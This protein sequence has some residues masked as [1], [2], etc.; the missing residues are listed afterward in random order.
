MADR[1]VAVRLLAKVD[2]YQ[3]GLAKASASTRSFTKEASTGFGSV[4]KSTAS[5]GR[6]AQ[7]AAGVAIAATTAFA[8]QSV[9][10]YAQVQDAQSALEATYGSS[11]AV[12]E[13][14]A[15]TQAAGYHLSQREAL[16][17][18]QTF[19]NFAKAAGLSGTELENF[20]VTL[21]ARAADMASYYGGTVQDAIAAVSSGLMGEQE[22]LRRYGVLL[23]DQTM[24]VKAL[25]MGLISSVKQGL[26]PQ[27]KV[28]TV[29]A[30]LLEK[31]S[32]AAGDAARTNGSLANNLKDLSAGWDDLQ[33]SMGQALAG[34]VTPLLTGANSLLKIVVGLPDPLKMAGAAATIAAAGFVL[35][36]PRIVDSVTAMKELAVTSPK[37]VAGLKGFVGI[38]GAVGVL[39]LAA[40]ALSVAVQKVNDATG[41]GARSSDTW[42][43]KLTDGAT[44]AELGD[45]A[46]KIALATDKG[47]QFSEF[48]RSGI[49]AKSTIDQAKT[50]VSNLDA[51]LSRMVS[52]G[53]AQLA[54]NI[55]QSL[56]MDAGGAAETLPAYTAA[57]AAA[58]TA[59]EGAVPPLK[60]LTNGFQSATTAAMTFDT[61]W[62]RMTGNLSNA[63]ALVAVAQSTA[64]WTKSIK[65]N[66]TSLDVN[67]AKG[68]KNI[69]SLSAAV[70]AIGAARDASIKHGTALVGT[71][72]ATDQADHAASKQVAA[73]RASYIAAG[74]TKQAFDTL[75][76]GLANYIKAPSK[77]TVTTHTVG[78]HELV[79]AGD[80]LHRILDAPSEKR[81]NIITTRTGGG[82]TGGLAGTFGV[83]GGVRG[84]G[85]STSDS[86]PAMLSNGEWVIQASAVKSMESRFGPGVM[87]A[88]NAG[89]LPG[90]KT[91]GTP[92]PLTPYQ[93]QSHDAV[94][95]A[96]ARRLERQLHGLTRASLDRLAS[97]SPDDRL[98]IDKAL[99]RGGRRAIRQFNGS[100]RVL[101]ADQRD[102]DA[103]QAAQD[104]AKA[105]ADNIANLVD[106]RAQ[107]AANV[108]QGFQS[109]NGLVGSF[110][111]KA[112]AGAVADLA[113]A[114][115]A[116]ADAEQSLTAARQ[117]SN[118]AGTPAEQAAAARDLAAAE[119]ALARSKAA[120]AA[121]QQ[122]V[123]DT[124]V[125]PQ[126]ILKK[127]A[128]KLAALS[129]FRSNIETLA[130]R[131]L[132]HATLQELISAGV[133][134]GAEMAAALVTMTDA[135]LGQVNTTQSQ[136]AA[137]SD[138]LGQ[139]SAN[140]TYNG[141]I[142]G[143]G[144]T[145]GQVGPLIP[146]APAGA[147]FAA[148]QSITV[149]VP[150]DGATLAQATL[151]YDRR[152]GG[153]VPAA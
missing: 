79:L 96:R 66:G 56:G 134:G 94:T 19:A 60:A 16:N 90:F 47:R 3:A 14:W 144:G 41:N 146:A 13:K 42:L 52:G 127:Y 57:V 124:A 104:A 81:I 133:D 88:L 122:Q 77:K 4:A 82:A 147:G 39:T 51:A 68:Q 78:T 98:G 118:A 53:Q 32:Q 15:Q 152:T 11:A 129:S 114:R 36:A 107:A 125:T 70:S 102:A 151:N 143:A 17:A 106:Q 45:V 8:V 110:D 87:Y 128:S 73:L 46:D 112:Q 65:E 72:R 9:K 27:Q 115:S 86:I 113:S 10:A 85:S 29:N 54:A 99:A 1:T 33:V 132:N 126:N 117:A 7:V 92:K 105:R 28:L 135:Q 109:A 83:G 101:G 58:G 142:A 12:F 136:I 44:G 18:E 64:E 55:V 91:G 20:T 141:Q 80:A 34:G 21:T 137:Q 76:A 103:R 140:M 62:A 59:T 138:W 95:I 23:D 108:S 67:S 63:S 150:V 38:A 35:L 6:G 50:D 31:S 24:R 22:P 153:Y 130:R 121:A 116:Q 25:E 89:D 69:G 84:P 131:G 30:L 119:T 48:L 26:T 100:T 2:A 120:V 61:A 149:Y 43:A 75:T 97:M 5:M 37:A 139:L 148:P 145:A 74:G 123:A 111:F 71:A 93:Q 49:G 40:D